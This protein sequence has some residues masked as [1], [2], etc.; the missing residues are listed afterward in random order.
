MPFDYDRYYGEPAKLTPAR[1][2]RAKLVKAIREYEGEWDFS[3]YETC[4]IGIAQRLG[5]G[6]AGRILKAIGL[7][8]IYTD[9]FLFAAPY[10]VRYH[11]EVTPE[12]V[13]DAL[14]AA[15]FVE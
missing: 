4:A 13:A 15:P 11:E 10:G 7:S 14:E 2:N 8:V 5:L 12:M 6:D 9:F 1:E 3:R